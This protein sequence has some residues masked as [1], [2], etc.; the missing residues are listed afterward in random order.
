M[1]NWCS[2]KF[3]VTG[4]PEKLAIFLQALG[5]D[6]MFSFQK[7]VPMPEELKDIAT[8]GCKIDGVAHTEWLET[9]DGPKALTEEFRKEMVEKHGHLDWYHWS[10]ANWGTKWDVGNDIELHGDPKYGELYCH[11]DTAWGPP[12]E[13][14]NTLSIRYPELTFSLYYAEGGVGFWGSYTVTNGE[15]EETSGVG[16]FWRERD[17]DQDDEDDDYPPVTDV[18]REFLEEHGLHTGG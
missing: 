11:F 10:I 4:E 5:E 8:G 14:L 6:R 9:P 15:G 17:E 13:F 2:N 3:S 12:I 18:V 16:K 1:P 7:L